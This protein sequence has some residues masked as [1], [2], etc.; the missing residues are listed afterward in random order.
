MCRIESNL[1]KKVL[2]KAPVVFCLTKVELIP[3]D[4]ALIGV[5]SKQKEQIA[6]IKK[7][8]KKYLQYGFFFSQNFDITISEQHK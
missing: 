8:I 5:A 7:K 2:D 1:S 4:R 6:K 3:F